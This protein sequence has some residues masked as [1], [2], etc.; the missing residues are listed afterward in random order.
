MARQTTKQT[1]KQT[2]NNK[3]AQGKDTEKAT[4]KPVEIPT[5]EVIANQKE[6]ILM[7]QEMLGI[8]AESVHTHCTSLQAV[9][10]GYELEIMEIDA[11]IANLQARRRRLEIRTKGLQHR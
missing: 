3:P 2:A 10:A 6:R 1:S 4:D 5:S 9:Q 11:D 8:A 7:Q